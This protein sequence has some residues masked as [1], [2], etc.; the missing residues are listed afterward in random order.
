MVYFQSWIWKLWHILLKITFSQF[1]WLFCAFS[2]ESAFYCCLFYC[3]Q[4]YTLMHFFHFSGRFMT[5]KQETST[6]MTW[7]VRWQTDRGCAANSITSNPRKHLSKNISLRESTAALSVRDGRLDVLVCDASK[8]HKNDLISSTTAAV[9]G[10]ILCW[11]PR[12]SH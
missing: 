3:A 1:C 7:T 6:I 2:Q 12:G 8:T 5:V 10:F 9:E 11:R 4:D